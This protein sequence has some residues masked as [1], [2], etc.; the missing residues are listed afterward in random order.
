MEITVIEAL[1]CLSR[2]QV[3]LKLRGLRSLVSFE[4]GEFPGG[5]RIRVNHASFGDF[6]H[7]KERSKDYHV[8]SEECLYTGFCDAFSLGC[9]M[10]G[11]CV[12]GGISDSA[13]PKGLPVTVA[14]LHDAGGAADVSSPRRYGGLV[15]EN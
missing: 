12:D 11:V 1:L 2:G 9:N 14:F 10:L 8:E 4:N 5:V 7:D 13:L 6:L 3:K 15:Q